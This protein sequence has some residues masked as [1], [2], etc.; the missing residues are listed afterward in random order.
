M[1]YDTYMVIWKKKTLKKFFKVLKI[2]SWHTNHIGRIVNKKN[3]Y[4]K[5]TSEKIPKKAGCGDPGF[6]DFAHPDLQ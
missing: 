5:G 4:L 3:V 1:Q 6:Q 2:F